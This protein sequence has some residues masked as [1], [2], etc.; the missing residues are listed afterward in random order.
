MAFRAVGRN[1]GKVVIELNVSKA[2]IFAF[3][4]L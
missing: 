2:T 1:L 4:Q 3:E